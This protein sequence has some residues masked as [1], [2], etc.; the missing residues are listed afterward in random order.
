MKTELLK[1]LTPEQIEKVQACKSQEELLQLARQEGIE[2]NDEQL[3]AV[4]G[5]CSED[6][7]CPKCGAPFS[8]VKHCVTHPEYDWQCKKCGHRWADEHYH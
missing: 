8:K 7:F 3:E 4:S 5:G 2:L 6:P 1:G